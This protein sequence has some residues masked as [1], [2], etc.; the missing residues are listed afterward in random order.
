MQSKKTIFLTGATGTMG[1]QGLKQLLDR[2]DR[3]NLI[4]LVLPTKRDR[5]EIAPFK[6][7]PGL[8]IVWGDLTNYED[9]FQCVSGADFV[10]H[11][12]GMVSPKAD[13]YP[14]L[15]MKV[16]I[17]AIQNILKAI[18][19]QPN[20]D[21]IKLVYIGSVAQTG[22]RNAPLHWGRIGDPIKISAFDHYALSKTLA[23]RE[24]IESGLKYWVSL[25]QTGILY[26]KIVGSLDPILF[27]EPLNGVLE[28]VTDTDSGRLLANVCAQ[29]IPEDFWCRIYNVGGGPAFR[30]VN[31]EFLQMSFEALGI[32]DF[33][34]VVERNWFATQNFHGQWYEDSDVLENYLHF[35]SGS[36]YDFIEALKKNIPFKLKLARFVPASVMKHFVFKPVAN[37][38]LGTLN[39]IINNNSTRIK[40]FFG[41]KE[42]WKSIPR[43]GHQKFE[44]PTQKP[45]R[46]NHG[47][48]ESKPLLELELSDMKQAAAFRGGKC[49]SLNMSKGDLTSKLR[50]GCAFGHTFEA[51]PRLVLMGGH[52]CPDCMPTPWNYE[53]EAKRN[54]FFAQVWKP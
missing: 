27:H 17:G 4:V 43:W 6:H 22:D 11:V 54:P 10:L 13:Y 24:V 9:V 35:R 53:E 1:M 49:L 3:F 2:R 15:T 18:K 51:S 42:N 14:E 26:G 25:R 8:K 34:K 46:L 36:L 12:G 37:K 21:Q 45:I 48:D 28:W 41:S 19:A 50:W 52:W 44:K 32:K 40:A 33:T 5:T 38:P 31:A 47:Y 39:W 20:P 30:T 7:T 16:N 29:D 23:E